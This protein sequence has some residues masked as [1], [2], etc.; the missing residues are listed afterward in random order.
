MSLLRLNSRPG[1]GD[2]DGAAR[3][4]TRGYGPPKRIRYEDVERQ[5]AAAQRDTRGDR[6][7]CSAVCSAAASV[8]TLCL[9]SRALSGS[10]FLP[11]KTCRI[12]RK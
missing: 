10:S 5:I 12:K 3:T 7:K 11:A 1:F 9:S 2:V 4:S 6:G 8:P